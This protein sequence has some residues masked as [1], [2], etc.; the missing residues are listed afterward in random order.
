MKKSLLAFGIVLLIAGSTLGSI[1]SISI[2]RWDTFTVDTPRSELILN[3]AFEIQ[4]SSNT[5]YTLNLNKNDTLTI[6]GAITEPESNRSI[7]AIIDFS[8]NDSSKTYHSYDKTQNL[9]FLW[10]VPQAGNYSFV[11]DN[12]FDDSAKDVIIMVMKN[13]SEPEQYSI[14]VN[15]PLVNYWFLWV[16]VA[17]I[18]VGIALAIL[19]LAKTQNYFSTFHK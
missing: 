3:K 10:T 13:W 9:T 18:I 2:P 11:F 1:S 7:G 17:L 6:T 16:G 8:I 5:A 12:R 14:M 4:A 19:W 15:T